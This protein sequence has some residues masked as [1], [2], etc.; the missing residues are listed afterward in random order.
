M[1]AKAAELPQQTPDELTARADDVFRRVQ[2]L[3]EHL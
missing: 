2:Q 3:K 1:A